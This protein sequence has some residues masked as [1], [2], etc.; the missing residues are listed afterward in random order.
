MPDGRVLIAPEDGPLEPNPT[1]VRADAPGG[2]FPDQFVSGFDLS[3]GKQ[4]LLAATDTGTATVYCNDHDYGLFDPRNASSPYYQELD[5]KQI[6]LQLFDPV[7]ETWETQFRGNI[8]AAHYVLDNTAVNN[9]GEPINCNIQLACSDR[10]GYLAGFGLTPG[11][12]GD[13]PPQGGADGIWYA[14]TT[15]EVFVRIIQI[16]ADAQIDDGGTN[17]LYVVFSGNVALQTV[18]YDVGESALSA[19]RDCAEAD[20][21]FIAAL[22]VDRLGRVVF[23]GRYGRFDSAAVAAA[24]GSDRWDYHEWQLGDGKSVRDDGR[25]QMRVLEFDRAL[26]NI[27]NVA[28]CYPQG[29]QTTQIPSQVYADSGSIGAYGQYAS[30]AIENLLTGKPI[31]DNLNGHP[32]WDRY[33][34]CLKYA[35]LLVKNQ[36]DPRESITDL[37][38]KTVDPSDSRATDVWAFL[39]QADVSDLVNVKVG[40][41]H[42][43]GFT[44]ASPADDYFIEGRQMRV[45][46]LNASTLSSS[47]PGY[48]YVE[49][50]VAVSPAI[51][52]QDTHGVFPAWPGGI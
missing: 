45:R 10:F 34:E 51:W 6:M 33:T 47:L 32:T 46:P 41:P 12:A 24:A 5:N 9:L 39:T 20:A 2:D 50:D 23:H 21:P 25:T 52:S 35:E 16:L 11:L 29:T 1:W 36:K 14:P 38:V 43:T 48:D 8:D 27:V 17:T 31:T 13:R 42:G 44:G 30:P 22:Y 37:Q 15:D 28:T 49:L 3:N 7:L 19:L 4:T 18:K 26:Q 40:Y